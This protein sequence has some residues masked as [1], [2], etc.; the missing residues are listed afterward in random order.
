MIDYFTKAAEFAASSRQYLL[1]DK[2]PASV[3]RSLTM[4]GFAGILCLVTSRLTT[5]QIVNRVC[6]SVGSLGH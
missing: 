5:A 4:L 2:Q 3:A 6:A 1:Y